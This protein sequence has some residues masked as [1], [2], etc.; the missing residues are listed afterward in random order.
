L[1]RFFK[2]TSIALILILI[3]Q[4]FSVGIFADGATKKNEFTGKAIEF[5]N[6]MSYSSYY[7]KYKSTNKPQN[8]IKINSLA[9]SALKDAE[10]LANHMEE[11][12]VVKFG[13]QGG[14][15]EYTANVPAGIYHLE[16]SYIS[17]ADNNTDL[18]IGVYIDN[19]IPFDDS[20]NLSLTRSWKD[21]TAITQDSKGND[22][23]P[24]QKEVQM[25]QKEVQKHA[26]SCRIE[27]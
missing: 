25:W 21:E 2:I 1:S 8:D 10:I 7:D 20:Q 4:S 24:M 11:P 3:S 27:L 17:K 23:L 6:N 15:V 19:E 9:I 22:I 5:F 18:K 26:K 13:G 12:A 14:S 16:V